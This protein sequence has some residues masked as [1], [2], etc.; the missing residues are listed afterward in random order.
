MSE[1]KDESGGLIRTQAAPK[2]VGAYPHARRVGDFIFVSGMGP[3][4]A[5]SDAIPGGPIKDSEG[6]PRDY[7][8]E[9]QTRAVIENIKVVL[10]AAGSSLDRVVDCTSFLVDM[11]RDFKGYNRVYAEYF[12]GI[13]ATRTT[14]AITALPTPIAVEMK[15]IAL[16]GDS[17]LS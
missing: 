15:V 3:R 14:I 1:S 6:N 8:I 10:E 11:D 12:T 2:P 9:A 16:A 5:G 17:T 13:Q 4:Q 7:D